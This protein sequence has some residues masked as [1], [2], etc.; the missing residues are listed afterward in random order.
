MD[1]YVSRMGGISQCTE[2]IRKIAHNL[3]TFWFDAA[4]RE[5]LSPAALVLRLPS[6][7][8]GTGWETEDSCPSEQKKRGIETPEVST[9]YAQFEG[10][11]RPIFFRSSNGDSYPSQ[12]AADSTARTRDTQ[13]KINATVAG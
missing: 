3:D 2:N 9:L 12:N 1:G 6:F 13:D 7:L 11:K 5:N 8:K 10:V 4:M